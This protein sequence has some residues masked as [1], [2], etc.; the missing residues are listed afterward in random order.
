MDRDEALAG[1]GLRPGLKYTVAEIDQMYGWISKGASSSTAASLRE[2]WIVARGGEP[3]NLISHPA[4][5]AGWYDDPSSPDDMRYWQ[6]VHWT[7]HTLPKRQPRIEDLPQAARLDH[8]QPQEHGRL[9]EQRVFSEPS[10]HWQGQE[11]KTELQPRHTRLG[12]G[13]SHDGNPSEPLSGHPP[14]EGNPTVVVQVLAILAA[15]MLFAAVLPLSSEYYSGLRWFVAIVALLVLWDGW[16]S[17]S[18]GTDGRRH[19]MLLVS[20]VLVALAILFNPIVPVWMDREQWR[21]IDVLG[22]AMLLL[23]P[24]ISFM[25]TQPGVVGKQRL[26][27]K[28]FGVICLA[29][30]ALATFSLTSRPNLAMTDVDI[31]CVSPLPGECP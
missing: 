6:G 2:C 1:L 30:A 4:R 13:F 5:Q 17:T 7:E 18:S 20:P 15:L 19:W 28:T 9:H 8:G 23:Y 31:D 27:V 11:A 21:V 16:Q 10:Q 26:D 29:F 12:S 3:R 22:G 24:F 25:P 14:N